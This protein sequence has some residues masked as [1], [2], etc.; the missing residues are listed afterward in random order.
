MYVKW[1]KHKLEEK[2]NPYDTVRSIS[3]ASFWCS[4]RK[5]VSLAHSINQN[6]HF[7][8]AFYLYII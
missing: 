1:I 6:I 7:N 3:F 4:P 8:L 5:K 2:R